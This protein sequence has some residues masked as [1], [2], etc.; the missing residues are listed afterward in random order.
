MTSKKPAW[1]EQQL[2]GQA[3]YYGIPPN[4]LIEASTRSDR[5]EAHVMYVLPI[6]LLITTYQ[7]K[8]DYTAKSNIT[9]TGG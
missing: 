7:Y 2:R 4:A 9:T 1:V 8:F 3:D 6:P 5:L